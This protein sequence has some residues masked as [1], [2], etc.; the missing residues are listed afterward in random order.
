[1]TPAELPHDDRSARALWSRVA[2]PCDPRV[3]ELVQEHG[4]H[5][6]A[7]HALAAGGERRH[8]ALLDRLREAVPGRDEQAGRRCGARVVVPGDAGWP[9]GLDDLGDETPY[10]LWVRGPV[11][12]G[13]AMRRSVAVVGSR[14]ASEYGQRIAADVGGGLAAGDFTVVSG[15]ALGIDGAAHRGALVEGGAT[16]AVLAGG[17]DRPYPM[18]HVDLIDRIAATGALVSEVA[19]GFA[20]SRHRFLRRN[21]II[22]ALTRGTVVV[23]AGFR[24]GALSTAR[25]ALELQRPVGAFPGP[26]T[27]A[28]SAGC[29]QLVRDGGAVL[30]TDA[31]E[32]AELCGDLG[33]DLAPERRGETRDDD[34]LLPQDSRLLS[35]LP[36][37]N[38]TSLETVARTAGLTQQEARAAWGRLELAGLAEL[39]DGQL[40]LSAR[41][42]RQR[43]EAAARQQPHGAS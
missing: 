19:P 5:V 34:L 33:R 37:R 25:R 28:A 18:A 39:R 36:Y 23:E 35:A 29:H 4:D 24:S 2:E 38:A 41:A 9:P 16:V 30:V 3:P 15:A 43:Q 17:V 10:C 27:S 12:L 22:A 1:M 6:A 21:R 42:R 8:E 31:A 11:S 7:L 40:R 32:V 14:A 20:P 26:V 13:P